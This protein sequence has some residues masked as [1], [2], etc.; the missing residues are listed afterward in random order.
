M[1]ILIVRSYQYRTEHVFLL[2]HYLGSV[3]LSWSHVPYVFFWVFWRQDLTQSLRGLSY[4]AVSKLLSVNKGVFPDTRVVLTEYQ[5][6]QLQCREIVDCLVDG[7]CS[8][9]MLEGID[10]GQDDAFYPPVGFDYERQ[11]K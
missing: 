6:E 2:F 7:L 1:S 5:Y 8:G 3:F 11:R 4:D 9:V 10:L